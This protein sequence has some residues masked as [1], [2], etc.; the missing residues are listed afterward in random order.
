LKYR[1]QHGLAVLSPGLIRW[2]RSPRK[3][4]NVLAG[5]ALVP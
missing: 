5:P 4:V 2:R 1:E 3:T